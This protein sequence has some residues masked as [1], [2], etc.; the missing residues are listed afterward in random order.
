MWPFLNRLSRNL[1]IACALFPTASTACTVWGAL[2]AND[3]LVAKNR[4]F[5]PGNQQFSLNSQIHPSSVTSKYKYFGLYADNQFDNKYLIKMGINETGLTV[6]MTFA[7]SIPSSQRNATVPYYQVMEEILGNYNNIDAIYKNSKTLFQNSTPINYVFADRN[8]AMICEIGLKNKY[9]CNIFSRNDKNKV[10]TFAQTNHYIFDSLK[11]DN[12]VPPV[13]QQTSYLR[14]AKINELMQNHSSNLSLN[15][16]I[17]FSL[18]TESKNDNPL[19]KFDVGYENT[20]QDNSILRTFNSHPDR[21]DPEDP[22]SDQAVSSMIIK[23]SHDKHKPIELY[24]RIIKSITDV[25]NK[26]YPQRIEYIE[27]VT[28]LDNA[29]SHPDSIHF[30]KK[31]CKRNIHSKTCS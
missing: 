22:N 9:Q 1:I 4:D 3:I 21:K 6:L 18:N 19:A 26:K 5:Y 8:K 27:A 7:S 23:I 28:T 20:Y 2:T 24:L 15:Q 31:S 10:L 30:Q 13:N 29:I 12:L 16:F 14:F 17:K 11:Q 25:D